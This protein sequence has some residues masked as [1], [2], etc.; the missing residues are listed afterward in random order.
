MLL[1]ITYF[2]DKYKEKNRQQP[3][4]SVAKYIIAF[5]AGYKHINILQK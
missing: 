4:L 3:V 2:T 5:E 1:K